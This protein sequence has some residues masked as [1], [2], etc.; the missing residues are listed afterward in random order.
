MQ[1]IPEFGG[2]AEGAEAASDKMQDFVEKILES[3]YVSTAQYNEYDTEVW[4]RDN[5]DY[6]AELAGSGRQGRRA[7]WRGQ[8]SGEGAPRA[9]AGA[10]ASGETV[11]GGQSPDD[12][13][14][15][16]V[17]GLINQIGG[18]EPPVN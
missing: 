6:D 7:A 2:G 8:S 17:E 14:G 16:V 3:D 5:G 15:A 4:F 11:R 13:L 18:S 10:D 12:E 1:Y 9:D